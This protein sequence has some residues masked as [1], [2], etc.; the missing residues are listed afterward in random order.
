[1]VKYLKVLFFVLLG[2]VIGELL[3]S[4]G[5]DTTLAVPPRD[6]LGNLG[7]RANEAR[8]HL[9]DRGLSGEGARS[10]RA[11]LTQYFTERDIT[12]E[13]VRDYLTE[14][15]LT[16]DDVA[17]GYVTARSQ[18]GSTA[19][20]D[21][22]YL[23]ERGPKNII[24]GDQHDKAADETV[25][26]QGTRG[27]SGA[28]G[29]DG[30]AGLPGQSGADGAAGTP[31]IAGE[32]GA[33]GERGRD[34]ESCSVYDT[35]GGAILS[36]G[37]TST[38]IS[39]GSPGLNGQDGLSCTTTQLEGGLVVQ[40]GESAAFVSNGVNG[41]AGETGAAGQ[42]GADAPVNPWSIAE[43]LSP[44]GSS[45]LDEVLIRFSNG[46]IMAHY[47]KANRQHL[48]MLVPGA[49]STTETNGGHECSFV[50]HASGEVTW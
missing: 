18:V 3:V 1:M 33:T 50:V 7:A 32:T 13:D 44:C 2:V 41:E 8:E 43:I 26:V 27:D 37:C 11:D 16:A 6:V 20:V 29:K 47:S 4:C 9:S 15:N 36:C 38:F 19:N 23:Y 24:H 25:V 35:E 48:T 30:T 31:G 49:Y 45:V 10:K 14:R 42:D 46:Q 12:V 39:D 22:K 17:N 34:G 40:C 5:P 28:A 21:R